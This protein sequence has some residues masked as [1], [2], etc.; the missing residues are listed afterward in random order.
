MRSLKFDLS[1]TSA[2]AWQAAVLLT[3][4]YLAGGWKADQLLEQLPSEFHGG[5][6]KTCQ[7]LFLGALRHGHRTRA[8]LNPFLRKTPR[9]SVEA[10]FLVAAYELY[11]AP[12]EKIPKII[13]HAVQGSK[14]RV[15]KPESAL[16]NAVLRKLPPVFVEIKEN[17]LAPA[18]RFSHPSWLVE[19]WAHAF[20]ASDCEALLQWNQK[21]PTTYIRS[22]EAL[23]APFE[24]TQWPGFYC[25]PTHEP[26]LERIRP[27]LESGRAYVKD[28]STRLAPALLNTQPGET[29]LD[30]CAAP[31][32]KAFEITRGLNG[33][34]L[35]LALDLPGER[36]ERLNQNLARME[37]E[38]LVCKSLAHD[39]LTLQPTDLSKNNYPSAFDAV[40]LDAPCSNTGVIQR[41]TDVK[42]RLQA[43]DLKACAKIQ[44]E[45]L[46][47]AGQF[48]KP[49]GR[50]VYSTCSIEAS[51]NIEIVKA[52]LKSP[53]GANFKLKDQ[54]LSFP[55]ETGH[56]GA[57]AFLLQAEN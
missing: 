46:V 48:V 13:H 50:L 52:F 24:A 42:W 5:R 34:G 29:V 51:E 49:G 16:I 3:D 44:S 35:L 21:I 11:E 41:R 28:P 33:K 30:L 1:K 22:E 14:L 36:M 38:A 18:H 37:N 39:L 56:D 57:G 31:G 55:W 53:A 2:T 54:S 15:S 40:L 32:G 45:L 27:F 6:R 7:S 17:H 20:K 10:I 8:A 43:K 47:A 23:P 4:A 26:W 25:A 12:E 19:H 9:T